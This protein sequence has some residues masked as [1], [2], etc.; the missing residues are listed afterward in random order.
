MAIT[1]KLICPKG[2]DADAKDGSI[3]DDLLPNHLNDQPLR[4]SEAGSIGHQ[5]V[6]ADQHQA[7]S[8]KNPGIGFRIVF[9]HEQDR[10]VK[11]HRQGE[12]AEGPHN[13]Q[14]MSRSVDICRSAGDTEKTDARQHP[15][16]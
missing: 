10:N 7:E 16:D 5:Q 13:K 14:H 1:K 8:R 11:Q 4:G 6:V 3:G 2:L 9:I 12:E 15:K